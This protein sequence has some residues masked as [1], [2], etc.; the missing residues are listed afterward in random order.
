METP[1]TKKTISVSPEK[2]KKFRMKC[3]QHEETCSGMLERFMEAINE[4]PNG[5][6]VTLT[7][8]VDAKTGGQ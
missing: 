2:W 5:G 4:M 6:K 1:K 3:L 7:I 8:G